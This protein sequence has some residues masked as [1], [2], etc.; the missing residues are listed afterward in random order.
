MEYLG[1][2]QE[3]RE[4]LLKKYELFRN[5]DLPIIRETKDRVFVHY[6]HDRFVPELFMPITN[7]MAW[8]KPNGGLW[9]SDVASEYSWKDW[10]EIEHFHPEKYDS[11]FFF[12]K[13]KGDARI[14]HLRTIDDLCNAPEAPNLRELKSNYFIDFEKLAQYY[15]AIDYY[16]TPELHYPLYGWDCDSFLVMNP[17]IIRPIGSEDIKGFTMPFNFHL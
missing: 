8:V 15:D 6:G 9:S 3:K 2:S 7:V 5:P 16:E 13:V 4:S 10:C 12:F 11:K 17:S 14:F 1:T